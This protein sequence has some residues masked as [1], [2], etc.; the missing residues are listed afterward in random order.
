M[1]SNF[2]VNSSLRDEKLIHY[3]AILL[4]ES[5]HLKISN[6]LKKEAVLI[7]SKDAEHGAKELTETCPELLREYG[8][9][10]KSLP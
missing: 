9:V 1:L 2:T 7:L 3:N 5:S 10:Q 6:A 4:H 8:G